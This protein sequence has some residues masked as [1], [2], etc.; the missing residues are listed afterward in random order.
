M[1]CITCLEPYT[2]TVRKRVE[3]G[4][5]GFSACLMCFEKY[6][7]LAVQDPHCMHCKKI[8]SR[9]F[10]DTQFPKKFVDNELKIHR[11]DILFE[12]EKN[13]LVQTQHN[14][15]LLREQRHI[16]SQIEVCRV[17]VQEKFY[18]TVPK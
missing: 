12:R 14:V 9:E 13:L 10:I 11:E 7:L 16:E 5:C 6:M 17:G 18:S 15:S 3:C 4:H 8:W 2:K 1:E